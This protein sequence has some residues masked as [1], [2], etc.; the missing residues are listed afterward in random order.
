[1]ADGP[2]DEDRVLTLVTTLVPIGGPTLLS[3]HELSPKESLQIV[4]LLS[5]RT[6]IQLK[7]KKEMRAD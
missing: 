2:A 5:P 1:V 7:P 6:P 4:I 3:E